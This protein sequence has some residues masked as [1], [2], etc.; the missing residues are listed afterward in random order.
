MEATA[1]VNVE[2]IGT[3]AEFMNRYGF[4]IIFAASI[5]LLL[6][7]A[8]GIYLHIIT[9]KTTTEL[10][11]AAKEKQA[12]LD[13][14]AAMFNLVTDVQT[15]QITQLEQI[16]KLLSD[17]SPIVSNT[18]LTIHSNT[19]DLEIIRSDINS[20]G[21]DNSKIQSLLNEILDYVKEN[22]KYNR[23]IIEKVSALESMLKI[24]HKDELKQQ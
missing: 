17:I 4:L 1:N 16:S 19:K 15:K 22:E 2:S 23:E 5:L 3:L 6:I 8:M 10:E 21:N 24:L 20:I 12:T 11:L 13:Q 14:N 7:A 9:K 18:E